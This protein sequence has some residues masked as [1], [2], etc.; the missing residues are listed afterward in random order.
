MTVKYLTI[1]QI[2]TIAQTI[3]NKVYNPTIEHLHTELSNKITEAVQTFVGENIW[4]S[5]L[6]H[7]EFFNKT[8]YLYFRNFY[9]LIHPIFP[10]ISSVS[11]GFIKFE[12]P[13]IEWENFSSDVFESF[14]KNEQNQK[15]VVSF[16]QASLEKQEMENKIICLLSKTLKYIPR[17][18]KE[19]PEAY[20]VY[21]TIVSTPELTTSECDNIE[22]IRAKLISNES[23]KI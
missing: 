10:K 3:S 23:K 11:Q 9:N 19:F 7:P 5:F 22:N 16:L 6:S 15:L 14:I 1:I 13:I 12:K 8:S 4:T 17:L 20:E 2:E 21:K 18:Q